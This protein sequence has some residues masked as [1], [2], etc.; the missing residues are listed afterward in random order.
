MCDPETVDDKTD[1]DTADTVRSDFFEKH[2]IWLGTGKPVI[3]PPGYPR[4]R[5]FLDDYVW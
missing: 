3:P 5:Q 4:W 1:E 2:A